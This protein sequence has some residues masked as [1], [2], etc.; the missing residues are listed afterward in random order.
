MSYLLCKGGELNLSLRTWVTAMYVRQHRVGKDT[1]GSWGSLA[2]Q[3]SKG[4]EP[5]VHENNQV[6]TP[7]EW[8]WGLF[9]AL[10]AHGR[11][12][13]YMDMQTQESTPHGKYRQ[14]LSKP[15]AQFQDVC[16]FVICMYAHLCSGGEAE[17]NTEC[18]SPSLL[19]TYFFLL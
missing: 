10:H 11:T 7:E 5:Q 12:Y 16:V 15:D 1:V 3:P 17:G 18:L 2:R 9:S 19:L 4:R 6:C 13:A 14:Q 8:H